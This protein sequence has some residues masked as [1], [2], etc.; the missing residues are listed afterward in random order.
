M[1]FLSCFLLYKIHGP[2][3]E[4]LSPRLSDQR[5]LPSHVFVG[6]HPGWG[7]PG[8]AKQG[9]VPLVCPQHCL[10]DRNLST[11][12]QRDQ[13]F[14]KLIISLKIGQFKSYFIATWNICERKAT[15]ITFISISFIFSDKSCI[16]EFKKLFWQLPSSFV[17]NVV[18]LHDKFSWKYF[19]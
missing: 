17:D 5:A 15:M 8:A 10:Y 6:L 9:Q 7:T 12:G 13:Y 18:R 4:V 11:Q 19:L 2:G 14:E 3:L 1:K 16:T